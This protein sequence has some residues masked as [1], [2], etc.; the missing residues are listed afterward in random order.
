M[1]ASGLHISGDG[2]AKR[3]C[4]FKYDSNIKKN[5]LQQVSY[6]TKK[7]SNNYRTPYA[8][9]LTSFCIYSILNLLFAKL[10]GN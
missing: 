10:H 1:F 2:P 8:G 7:P 5:M 6:F 4:I 9:S 3:S